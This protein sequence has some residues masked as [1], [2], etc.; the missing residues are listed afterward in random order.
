LEEK[1]VKP[2]ESLKREQEKPEWYV[3]YVT[4]KHE[5][6]AEALLIR[7]GFE[8]Y[9]PLIKT[10]KYWKQRKKWLE[11]P[12]FKS[13]IFVKVKKNQLYDVLQIP[14][15]ITYVRFSGEPA[16][17]RQQHIDLIKE[18]IINKT[19]FELSTKTIKVGEAIKLKTG[20]FKGQKGVVKEIRGKKRLLVSLESINFTLEIE[21]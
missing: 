21:L 14:S 4:A 15:I 13:Y 20:P 6:K 9:L 18:L 19:K 8:P 2:L 12:L 17:I 7:D 1:V 3:F 10:L 11:E 16:I 5:R